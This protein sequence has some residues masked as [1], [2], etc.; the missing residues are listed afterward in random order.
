MA[1][2]E[3]ALQKT[4]L[5]EGGYANDPDDPGGETY[6]GVAR[7]IFSKW[8]GWQIVDSLKQQSGFPSSL[9]KNGDLQNKI[10]DFYKANFWDRVQ[11]DEINDEH[12]AS[13]IFDFAVN[14]GVSTSAILAQH[15]VNANPDGVI[16]LN[17]IKAINAMDPE[18]FLAA[19]TVAKVVRYVGIVNK[20]PASRK[21]FYGWIS[22][23]VNS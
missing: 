22:R 13:S 19:F 9:D 21:Y 10:R 20:R 7:N 17:T 5:N 4:L 3:T 18:F 2:F 1:L 23:A 15:V 11:G 12:V 6:K 8:D 14:T 16:G